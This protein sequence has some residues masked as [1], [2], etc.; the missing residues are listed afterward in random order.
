MDEAAQ[1][2]KLRQLFSRDNFAEH[3]GLE[4]LEFKP[5]YARTRMRLDPSH[6]NFLGHVH[7]GAIFGL[8]DY[9]F[10]AASNSHNYSSVA[11]SMSLQFVNAPP[12]AGFLY[13]EARE[14]D[15]SRKLGLYEMTVRDEAGKL[16]C[17]ADGRV[18]R[19]GEPLLPEEK[20][21]S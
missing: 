9:A 3:L 13:A 12:A 10:A 19:I 16:I 15:K 11:I 17:R 5:G 21:G 20:A 1:T 18:Y 4:L 2:E 7:G 14:L 6:L 8:L